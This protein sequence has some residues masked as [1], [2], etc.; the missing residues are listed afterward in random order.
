QLLESGVPATGAA[1]TPLDYAARVG[2]VDGVRL[3]IDY[4]KPTARTVKA[5]AGNALVLSVIAHRYPDVVRRA[6]TAALFE[7]LKRGSS[8]AAALLLGY[9]A[10]PD[11][12]DPRG[13]TPLHLAA[14]NCLEDVFKLLIELGADPHAKDRYGKAPLD[15]A[16]HCG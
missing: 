2:C 5:A 14:E 3:L 13:R 10:R 6:A 11:A 9:G 8:E 16:A 4:I 15:Y 12:R 7:A 1:D